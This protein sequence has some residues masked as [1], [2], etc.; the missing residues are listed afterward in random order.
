MLF[1]GAMLLRLYSD[2]SGYAGTSA[3][4]TSIMGFQSDN[5]IV[6]CMILTTIGMSVLLLIVLVSETLNKRAEAAANAKWSSL[7]VDPPTCSWIPNKKFACF[8]S[9]FK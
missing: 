3:A 7:A 9:H 4:A 8:L 1:F 6:G 2:F 5:A